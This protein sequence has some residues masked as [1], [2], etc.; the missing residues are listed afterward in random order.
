MRK[1][2]ELCRSAAQ[3]GDVPNSLKEKINAACSATN[4]ASERT[5]TTVDPELLA[6]VHRAF[7]N[8]VGKAEPAKVETRRENRQS[9]GEGITIG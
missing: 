7:Y 3:I 4:S 6:R 1:T 5:R 8:E 2:D 9:P